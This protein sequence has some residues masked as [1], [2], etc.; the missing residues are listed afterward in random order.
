MQARLTTTLIAAALLTV[1][2]GCSDDGG[3]PGEGS[4]TIS[5][6]GEDFVEDKIPADETDGWEIVFSTFEVTITDISAENDDAESVTV[7]GVHTLDLTEDSAGEG[8]IIAELAAPAGVYDSLNYR[9]APADGQSALRVAGTA[10]KDGITKTF[11]WEFDTDKLYEN[12]HTNA[13]VADGGSASS[14]LTIHADHLFYDDLVG[15]EPNVAF[16]LIASADADD[17]GDITLDELAGV[18]ITAE[19]RYQVGSR[20]I[21]DLRGFIEAQTTTVG[22]IDGEGHCD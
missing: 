6:Y 17:D 1:A 10:T 5:A 15:E 12:C 3:T 19:T 14:Q 18:D 7:D 22:H 9:I 11:S 2:A 8:H 13:D 21:T 20:D 4:Y 16:D